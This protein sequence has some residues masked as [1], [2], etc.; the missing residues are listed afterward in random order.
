VPFPFLL[1]SRL[2]IKR[3]PRAFL[4]V[5]IISAQQ[6]TELILVTFDVAARK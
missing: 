6:L 5:L 2:R 4:S 1:V 3:V